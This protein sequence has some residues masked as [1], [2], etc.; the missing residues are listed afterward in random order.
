M[1][2]TFTKPQRLF[3]VPLGPNG[4]L[5]HDHAWHH[6]FEVGNELVGGGNVDYEEGGAFFDLHLEWGSVC[7]IS[8]ECVTIDDSLAPA[9]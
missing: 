7:N 4:N 1:K 6:R 2:I 5:A 3:F 8:R 9:S